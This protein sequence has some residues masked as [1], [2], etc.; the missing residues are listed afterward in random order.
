M[1][2]TTVKTPIELEELS[3]ELS[4]AKDLFQVGL[5]EIEKL[6]NKVHY[7]DLV[8]LSELQ[9]ALNRNSITISL[10]NSAFLVLS[11]IID[12]IDTEVYGTASRK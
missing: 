2:N 7:K 4:R 6:P 1:T 10:L 8:Q 11:D 9:F 5:E 3:I 12:T